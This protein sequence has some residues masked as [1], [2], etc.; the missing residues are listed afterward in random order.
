MIV[1]ICDICETKEAKYEYI[2]PRFSRVEARGGKGQGKLVSFH[3]IGNIDTHFC[4]ECRIKFAA[5][6]QLLKGGVID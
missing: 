1:K 5:M 4:E 3:E 6:F 2:F